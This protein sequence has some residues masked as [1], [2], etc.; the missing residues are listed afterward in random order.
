MVKNRTHR[1]E[2]SAWLRTGAGLR[3]LL[4]ASL[5]LGTGMVQAELIPYTSDGEALVYSTE[6]DL[7]WTADANLFKTQCDAEAVANC[8]NL[9]A[10]IIAVGSPVTHTGTKLFPSP[11]KVR[12]IEFDQSNG[13]MTWFAA[14][15]WVAYLNSIAYGGASDW[16]QFEADPGD[17]NCSDNF[18]PGG[19]LPLEYYGFGCTGNE[20]GYVSTVSGSISPSVR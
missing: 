12:P 7:T 10:A 6:Q 19:G 16:R 1:Q 3:G 17:T 14:Q 20:L 2:E 4:A 9:I 15:A 8:P 11:H 13:M 5:L 18:D